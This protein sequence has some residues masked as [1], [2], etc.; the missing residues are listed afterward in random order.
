MIILIEIYDLQNPHV[1]SGLC[2]ALQTVN[3]M[4]SDKIQIG[5][6][7]DAFDDLNVSVKPEEYQMLAKTLDVDGIYNNYFDFPNKVTVNF[8]FPFPVLHYHSQAVFFFIILMEKV[9]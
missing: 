5:D 9:L 3:L 2:T 8:P 7:K 1:F 6:L 4:S